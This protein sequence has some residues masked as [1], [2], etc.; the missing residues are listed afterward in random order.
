MAPFCLKFCEEVGDDFEK[1]VKG[2]LDANA[3]VLSWEIYNP[4]VILRRGR[5]DTTFANR[6]RMINIMI[7]PTRRMEENDGIMKRWGG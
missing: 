1:F 6:G 7:F 2:V 5:R 4:A 3:S